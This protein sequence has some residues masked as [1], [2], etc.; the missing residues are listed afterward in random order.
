MTGERKRYSADFKARVA[1][2]ALRGALAMVWLASKH[3]IHQMMAGE[4]KK[5]VVEGLA[6]VFSG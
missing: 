2:E 1:L 5:Q 3:G 6:V 4:W